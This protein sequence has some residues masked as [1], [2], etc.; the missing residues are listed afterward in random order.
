MPSSRLM[1]RVAA[2]PSAQF[3]CVVSALLRGMDE[4]SSSRGCNWSGSQA[5]TGGCF[6]GE[7]YGELRKAWRGLWLGESGPWREQQVH[8]AA[9]AVLDQHLLSL[10]VLGGCCR[11]GSIKPALFSHPH[12]SLHACL[13]PALKHNSTALFIPQA[14]NSSS[15]SQ[16]GLKGL[17]WDVNFK[18]GL[19]GRYGDPSS[20]GRGCPCRQVPHLHAVRSRC[21]IKAFFQRGHD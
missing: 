16:P 17:R 6:N 13:K 11:A 7:V 1:L 8:C 3:V 4:L 5:G 20:V 2:G 14:A 21:G 10:P 18:A 9:L 15:T 12:Y 19:A